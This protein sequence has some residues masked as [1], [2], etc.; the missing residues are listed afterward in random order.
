MHRELADSAARGR[1]RLA[2]PEWVELAALVLD[3]SGASHAPV[4]LARRVMQ[5]LELGATA[6]QAV[7]ALVGE[8]GL[9]RRAA[10]RPDAFAEE[11]V[12]QLAAHL[13]TPDQARGLYVLSM[14]ADAP[15][16]V[17]R[18]RTDSLLEL[19]EAALAHPELTSRSASNTI[20]QRR[21]AAARFTE[22][23]RVKQRLATAPRA[24]VLAET[25][26]ALALSGGVV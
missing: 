17:E 14:A 12:L 4:L 16:V 2:H 3:A 25:S 10:L 21:N 9:L 11:R 18:A 24:Y 22:D 20:E 23:P 15:D 13:G 8:V 19:I 6:E 5:R 26:E 1:P 7:A